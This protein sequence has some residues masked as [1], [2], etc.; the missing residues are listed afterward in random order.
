MESIAKVCTVAN[1]CSCN[2]L[3]QFVPAGIGFLR[4]LRGPINPV[5]A[6]RPI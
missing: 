3:P 5:T 2:R 4:S 6:C 1:H